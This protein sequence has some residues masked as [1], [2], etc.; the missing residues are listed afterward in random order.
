V[1]SQNLLRVFDADMAQHLAGI[2]A[3]AAVESLAKPPATFQTFT[4]SL[5]GSAREISAP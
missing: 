3:D 5:S 2:R 1:F 4:K